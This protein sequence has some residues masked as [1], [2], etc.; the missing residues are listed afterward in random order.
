MAAARAGVGVDG[1]HDTALD[2]GELVERRSHGGEAVGGAGRGRDDGVVLGQGLLVDAVD[3][4]GKVVARGSGDDDF[5]RAGVD[6][7]LRLRL[8]G[9]EAGALEHD[10]HADL[11]PGK[12]RGVLLGVD[13]DLL[14]V[15][16]DGAL[17]G[18]DLVGESV[19]ALRAV[20]LEKMGE[21]L[22]IGQVVDG[23]DFIARRTEHLP[24]RK[25]ADPTE[26]VD[27][28]SDIFCHNR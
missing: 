26:T 23:D 14:A 20:V 25:T 4:G 28:N 1:A 2:G 6:V 16:D 10:I 5:L 8:G 7:S 22:G 24:E 17:F 12:I 11:L 3:D 15:D 18:F 9:V 19:S 21:H 27:S 13:L